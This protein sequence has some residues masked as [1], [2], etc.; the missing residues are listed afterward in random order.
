LRTLAYL[1]PMEA[2]PDTPAVALRPDEAAPLHPAGDQAG[3]AVLALLLLRHG[4]TLAQVARD[5]P[6]STP[7]RAGPHVGVSPDT[8]RRPWTA[9]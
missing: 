9:A 1:A 8:S 4:A 6:D 7:A 2:P 5:L 3:R